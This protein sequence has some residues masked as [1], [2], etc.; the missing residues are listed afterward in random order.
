[1][2]K[3]CTE[4]MKAD[5]KRNLIYACKNPCNSC[6]SEGKTWWTASH[7]HC[8]ILSP[9]LTQFDDGKPLKIMQVTNTE[10]S[11]FCILQQWTMKRGEERAQCLLC[12]KKPTWGAWI[13]CN[14]TGGRVSHTGSFPPLP[15]HHLEFLPRH[16]RLWRCTV[17]AW[18]PVKMPLKI[19]VLNINSDRC[20]I[21]T[22]LINEAIS[23]FRAAGSVQVSNGVISQSGC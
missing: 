20:S 4:W 19:K 1:M 6:E 9:V 17:N 18:F 22:K 3:Y 5:L 23:N 14:A 21:T 10:M 8:C 11:Q 12:S 15:K 13:H 7:T 2:H 16:N